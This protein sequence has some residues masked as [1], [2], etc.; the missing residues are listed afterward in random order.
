MIFL[1]LTI[2]TTS[3]LHFGSSFIVSGAVRVISKKTM[4]MLTKWLLLKDRVAKIRKHRRPP[5]I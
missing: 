4:E 5:K 1:Q 3:F 2:Y